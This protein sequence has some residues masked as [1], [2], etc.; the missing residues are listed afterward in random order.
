MITVVSFN[1]HIKF[2]CQKKR[3]E[4]CGLTWVADVIY[5]NRHLGNKTPKFFFLQSKGAARNVGPYER[6]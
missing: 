6:M 3:K 4:F 1:Q 5:K 2:L